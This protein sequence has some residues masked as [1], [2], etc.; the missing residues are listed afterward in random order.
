MDQQHPVFTRRS[1]LRRSGLGMGSIGLG[2]LLLADSPLGCN[3]PHFPGTAKRVIHF[4]LNGG[5]SH[6]DTF[7]PKPAL[8]KYAGKPLPSGHLR[9]ERK[10]GA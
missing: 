10:T 5:P 1:F 9:T 2:N 3:L 6:I 7:D 8:Q 4:F